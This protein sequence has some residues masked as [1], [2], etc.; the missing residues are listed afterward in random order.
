MSILMVAA[1]SAKLAPEFQI[2][3]LVFDFSVLHCFTSKP[4]QQEWPEWSEW[5]PLCDALKAGAAASCHDK[6]LILCLPCNNPHNGNDTDVPRPPRAV[7]CLARF[8][9]DNFS[10]IH[11]IRLLPVSMIRKKPNLQRTG[12][13]GLGEKS[14][15]LRSYLSCSDTISITYK[16][17]CKGGVQYGHPGS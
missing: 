4:H 17:G 12:Q 2:K 11:T 1:A 3:S 5:S 8:W 7:D 6:S 16:G 14:D 13:F 15:S 9:K 10:N